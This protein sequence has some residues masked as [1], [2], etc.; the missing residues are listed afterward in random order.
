MAYLLAERQSE[1]LISW[2][3]GRAKCL[4][5]GRVA[6]RR[7]HLLAEWQ[8]EGLMSWQ[9]GRAKGSCLGRAAERQSGK[10]EVF[11]CFGFLHIS[12][13]RSAALPRDK[14]IF[15]GG[16]LIFVNSYTCTYV[17]YV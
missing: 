8:S 4:S 12:P 5:L 2:K 15:A 14:A 11:F 6:E 7:A 9:S 10:I 13:C 17:R 3:S 1:G 16:V